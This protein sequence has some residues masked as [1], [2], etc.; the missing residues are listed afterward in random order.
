VWLCS[1]IGRPLDDPWSV[2]VELIPEKD[3]SAADL[4]DAV[5]AVIVDELG[6]LP[7]L[8]ERLTRGEVPV[9]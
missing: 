6:S 7:E 5:Q 1:Q 8:V 2:A 9:W 3:A 4:Y